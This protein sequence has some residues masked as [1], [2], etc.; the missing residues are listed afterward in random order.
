MSIGSSAETVAI[1]YFGLLIGQVILRYVAD[2]I[3][4]RAS[5][6]VFSLIMAGGLLA[7]TL[8]WATSGGPTR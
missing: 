7:I 3:G 1:A 6:S 5:F 2:A 4:R 8:Y